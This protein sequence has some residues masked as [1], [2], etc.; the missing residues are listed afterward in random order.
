MDIRLRPP[1]LL[2]GRTLDSVRSEDPM[3]N[4]KSSPWCPFQAS[5]EDLER[6]GRDV[7][8][9]DAI[10]RKLVEKSHQLKQPDRVAHQYQI[11][12]GKVVLTVALDL[13][14]A[15]RG[16]GLFQPGAVHL[17]I[18]RISTGL[19]VPHVE[20]SLDFL[21][22][23]LAFQTPRG[24]RV[25]FLGINDPG[26]PVDNHIDFISVLHATAESAGVDLP[27]IG[28][29]GDHELVNLL[30]TQGVFATALAQRMGVQGALHVVPHLLKQTKRTIH[31]IT[32][33]QSYWTGIFNLG[34]VAGKFT[35][36]PASPGH[37]SPSPAPAKRLFSE[38]W[39]NRQR[40]ASVVFDMCWIPFLDE[41]RTP[42][43]TLSRDWSEAHKQHAGSVAFPALD[44]DSE[45]AQLWFDLSAEMGANPGNWV[46]DREGTLIGPATEFETARQIAY[47]LSQEGR[48]VLVA[49]SYAAVFS[50]GTID[51]TLA[52]ELRRRRSA[53]TQQGHVDTAPPPAAD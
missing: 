29:L 38:D 1:L 45:E 5:A 53:K 26:A 23:R 32:A 44:P 28:N 11:A 14:E 22:L 35:F 2:P 16:V 30:A 18:G 33:F 7:S 27:V 46:S 6:I 13:P 24:Q 40:G 36:V 9:I 8:E 3:S 49:P 21:G 51:E 43:S 50:T 31:S 41:E 48:R 19:G 4:N 42:M 10:Q 15:L 37:D 17:G 47:R 20:P 25:D 39:R 12:G 52:A 34:G